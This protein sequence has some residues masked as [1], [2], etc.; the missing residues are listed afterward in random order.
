MKTSMDFK[1]K[2][3]SKEN[4][5]IEFLYKFWHNP[6]N[7]ANVQALQT[8]QISKSTMDKFSNVPFDCYIMQPRNRREKLSTDI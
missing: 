8:L 5:M 2:Q 7:F 4:S 3:L 1:C 6:K